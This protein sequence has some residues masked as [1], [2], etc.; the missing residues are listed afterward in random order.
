VGGG[1]G[2]ETT[3]GEHHNEGDYQQNIRGAR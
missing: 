1:D 3:T 2:A